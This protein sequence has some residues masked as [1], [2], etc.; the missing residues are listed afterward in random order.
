MLA[1]SLFA[2]HGCQSNERRSASIAFYRPKRNF[3]PVDVTAI[4]ARPEKK[5]RIFRCLNE[6][7]QVNIDS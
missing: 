7:L 3:L 4:L 2:S 1:S 6:T 5:F